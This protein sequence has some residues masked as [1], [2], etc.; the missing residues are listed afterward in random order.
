MTQA[1][2]D[3]QFERELRA[4]LRDRAEEIA[5]RAHSTAEMTTVI[6]PRLVPTAGARRREA[7]LRLAFVAIVALLLVV[8]AIAI[9]TR[10]APP[11]LKL[12]LAVDVPLQGEPG[13]PSTVD[14]VKLALRD[15]PAIRSVT[16]ELPPSGVYDDSVRGSA[17]PDK[18]AQNMASIA[19]DPRYVAVI[20]PYHSFVARATI[21]VTNAAGLLECSPTNTAPGLTRGDAAAA[22]RPRP[23]R[24]N[25]VRVA[26]NDD[27]AATAAARLLFGVLEK[28]S[29][30][31]VT[32]T[33]PFAGGR[34]L[35]FIDAFAGLGGAVVGTGA[36]GDGGDAPAV[37]ARQIEGSKA[38][39]VFFDGPSSLGGSVLAALSGPAASMPFVGLD[40]IIDGPP[41]VAGS[42]MQAAGA[43]A[44]DAYGVFPTGIDPTFG[45]PVQAAYRAAYGQQASNFDLSSYAC[46]SVILDALRRLDAS[47]LADLA[48]WREALRAE[49][50]A[51]GQAYD[52][53]VGTIA[54]DA[55]GD[56]APQRVSIYRGDPTGNWTFWQMLEL[57]PGS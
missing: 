31:V 13:A 28:R 46:T 54:F 49:V 37:V 34:S 24:P 10:P 43:H 38:D 23:D 27:A 21:P 1:F 12:L 36:V 29:V 5:S 50:T 20:G 40:I 33:E 32:T 25:Y 9:G 7:L 44:D 11:P 53:A 2:G 16:L 19:A 41:S 8:A 26:S 47:H 55:N 51:P 52:T 15:V 39:S 17:D 35:T 56:A 42:F 4:V 45:P 18:G 3:D 6:T 14:A 57:P 48:D 30:F 22:I